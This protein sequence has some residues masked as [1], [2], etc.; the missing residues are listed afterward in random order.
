MLEKR[1]GEFLGTA[2]DKANYSFDSFTSHPVSVQY[3][4]DAVQPVGQNHGLC[5]K[6]PMGGRRGGWGLGGEMSLM[7]PTSCFRMD[8]W[9]Y[10]NKSFYHY[11]QSDALNYI[12]ITGEAIIGGKERFDYLSDDESSVG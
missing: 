7:V 3:G 10:L 11:L 2:V 9:P 12:A 1:R 6:L 5:S 8:A 4:V